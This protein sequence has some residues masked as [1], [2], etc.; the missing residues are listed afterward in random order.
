M[1]PV[2]L[3]LSK[4]VAQPL[5]TTGSVSFAVEGTSLATHAKIEI[6]GS[7]A[8][9]TPFPSPGSLT[10]SFK[11]TQGSYQAVGQI[12]VTVYDFNGFPGLINPF[13]F[14]TCY[15]YMGP[16][17][18]T[19][20]YRFMTNVITGSDRING[21]SDA[22]YRI[23][24]FSIPLVA[25]LD[26]DG[27]PEIIALGRTNSGTLDGQYAYLDAYDG[28]TGVV[29]LHQRLDMLSNG[30]PEYATQ[31]GFHASPGNFVVIDSDRDGRKEVIV[32]LP[33]GGTMASRRHLVSYEI[34]SSQPFT[35]TRKWQTPCFKGGYS[36]HP[37]IQVVDFDCDGRAE[38]LLY[39][40]IYDART[41]DLKITLESFDEN[42]PSY[43]NIS[44]GKTSQAY[45]G[46]NNY[47]LT[48]FDD[49]IAFAYVYD[50]D[51]DGRYEI[52]A[53]GKVYYDIR[54]GA[55]T[56][57]T[58]QLPG[59]GDGR[60]GVADMDD[61]GI[62]D[63][64]T[65]VRINDAQVNLYIW[66]PGFLSLDGSGN[67]IK[68]YTP[69]GEG[70][71][72]SAPSSFAPSMITSR[73]V[74]IASN[75]TGS[76]SYIYIGDIDGRVQVVNG[77][78]YRLP[79]VA[80]LS[81]H[82]TYGSAASLYH[83]NVN[84]LGQIPESGTSA[85][86]GKAGVIAAFT[87]DMAAKGELKLS[88]IMEHND[89]SGNT[90]FTMFDFDNDGS[91]EICYR[92]EQTLRII[93]A[94]KAF[95][96]IDEGVGSSVLFK[97]PCISFTG[98]EY[99]AIADIDNDN[100]AEIIVIGKNGGSPFDAFGFVYAVGNGS[101]DKFAPAWPVWNQF[102]YDPFKVTPDSI[103]TPWGLAVNRLDPKFNFVRE[104]KDES[105]AV[106]KT[107]TNYKPFNGT[108]RQAATIDAQ[109][110]PKYEPVAFLTEA[111]I[112]SSASSP[113]KP[114]ITSS[115][116]NHY[117]E[118]TV[119]N[120][121]TANG[122]LTPNT[123]IAVYRNN[124][125]SQATLVQTITLAN[126]C[127]KGTTIPLGSNF[128]ISAGQE[129]T[130]W[131][132]IGSGPVPGS[133]EAVVGNVYIVRLGDDSK[134]IGSSW[135]W[136][137]GYNGG[138]IY[139]S[140]Y[141][142]PDFAQGIGK[143]SRAF[144]DCNWCD[145]AV[146]AAL[147]QALPDLY[148]IGEFSSV[149]AAVLGNDILPSVP[150]QANPGLSFIDT[151]RLGQWNIVT[152]PTAGYLSF[153]NAKGTGARIT[154]THDD[155]AD[156]PHGID[157]F[158]YRVT[159][160]DDVQAKLDSKT[161]TVYVYILKSAAGG[162]SSCHGSATRIE[163]Q[164]I[165]E[166]ITFEWYAS[167]A[168]ANKLQPDSTLRITGPMLAD[169]AYW[170]RPVT[171]GITAATAS[172]F[173]TLDF[174]RGKLDIRLATYPAKPA[175]A[176]RWT[177]HV[178]SKWRNPGN[179]VEVRTEGGKAYEA[180]VDY[181]PAECSDVIIPSGAD[182]F[183]ELTDTAVCNNIRLANRAMLANPHALKYAGASVEIK[184]KPS[185]R[186][187]FVMWSAPLMSMYSG[188]YHY[189]NPSGAPQWGDAF[190]NLF[191]LANPDGGTAE[192]N[193]FTATFAKV[194]HPL[195]L[196]VPFN[197]KV[198]STSFTRD[199]LLRFPRPDNYYR[200][201]GGA[202]VAL[203]SRAN[204]DKFITH[205]VKP[206]PS[207][208][209]FPLP[210]TGDM[211]GG[212]L[213]RLV[214]VVNPY[215]AYLSVD[216]FLKYNPNL[217]SGY[218]IWNGEPG[219]SIT[220]ASF[221]QGNRISVSSPIPMQPKELAYVPPLQSFFVAKSAPEAPM[222]SVNMSARWT[223]TKPVDSY[224]LR[225]VTSVT[226]GGTMS[227][228]LSGRSQS[229]CAAMVYNPGTGP[230]IDREDMPAMAIAAGG[231]ASIAVYAFAFGGEPLA[232]NNSAHFDIARV[233]LGLTVNAPGKY[234]LEFG[235]LETFGYNVTLID[236]QQGYKSVDLQ[237]EPA[238]A[239]TVGKSGG[240]AIV[241]NNRFELQFVY[242][243][244]GPTMAPTEKPRASSPLHIT[245]G[246]AFLYVD[247]GP[248]TIESVKVYDAA[249]HCVYANPAANVAKLRIALPATPAVYIVEAV[250]DGEKRIGKG[251]SY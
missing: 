147:Y 185:E 65:A 87:M 186:D 218:Y 175:S 200:L 156:L 227:I 205:G 183:P 43:P 28:R 139:G 181:P 51:L 251:A 115:G 179:W 169:S 182:N 22:D 56:Y 184:L 215:M 90:G 180:P 219:A 207:T 53:G 143:A 194:D 155:C 70:R 54:P 138:D 77:K 248:S 150:L 144:R 222:A 226:S 130:I 123:P 190:M 118:L 8:T 42:A 29:K 81:G 59:I 61:N 75:I 6:A 110:I 141:H 208:G 177:G 86:A 163:L 85:G 36:Q 128:T 225:S 133:G 91:Q 198:T 74:K 10:F 236:K 192:P 238:Y 131:I 162:F 153:N 217:Q 243:G 26:M 34:S 250:V 195:P 129:I 171:A 239:F 199:S 247:A 146:R 134:T 33:P 46:K 223:T 176:M 230:S 83:P 113:L 67:A 161:A 224:A 20:A 246:R 9:V 35:V 16:V 172:H 201:P 117:I 206:D 127:A 105:G 48:S 165:P 64:V 173:Q 106:T 193:R 58:L 178:N 25:D 160:Y 37:V 45:T 112:V 47:D 166:G 189:R 234:R 18:F 102:M 69:D 32:A 23:Y 92:D 101:G 240:Q 214:Q 249:G 79:E 107:I 242:T 12:N 140:D 96:P 72:G 111:Y 44:I 154:Y 24:G 228:K 57:K 122:D 73:T 233:Q 196:G 159:Y 125:I 52:A 191:Q 5:P 4:Y 80:I 145:Q 197:L 142:C 97:T 104:I 11:V 213:Q 170:I 71:N 174:P 211:S 229:A 76:N 241:V 216:S 100:S 89:G 209:I 60:T 7:T 68:N 13:A 151:V 119:G 204:R 108:L 157:S 188:D 19:S 220:A 132:P 210:V 27:Y 84:T 235:G 2:S 98:F 103:T 114:K 168:T 78:E 158:R 202:T 50:L 135:T 221:A 62:P 55:G 109:A 120:K 244:K 148:V 212:G 1:M 137:F 17:S 30:W 3:D 121:P 88:F 15:D 164:A 39:N 95:I 237:A 82:Y 116:N 49:V 187:R 66:N 136:R 38:I 152:P 231:S 94:N 63:V 167:P 126:T 245:S 31:P 21:T 232:V 41:G 99:P 124:T 203:P 40:K 14:N 149:E 93:K